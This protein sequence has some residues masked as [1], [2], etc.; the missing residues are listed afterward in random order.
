MKEIKNYDRAAYRFYNTQ[1]IHSLPINSWD[2]FGP[3]FSR[4]CKDQKDLTILSKLSKENKWVYPVSW[5]N[6]LVKKE[7]IIVVTDP[8]L[9][10]VHATHNIFYMNGYTPNEILGKKPKIFQGKDT[11]KKTTALISSAIKEGQDFNVTLVNYH[12]D[13]SAYNCWIKGE[14]IYNTK[15]KIVN[16]IAYERKVA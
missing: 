3:Y 9:N 8:H 1:R 6:Q 13:G 10:I 12:K 2:L 7:H 16:F 4:L 14:P 5:H 15:G 11:C